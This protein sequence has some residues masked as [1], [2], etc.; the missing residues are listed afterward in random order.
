[1]LRPQ[2]TASDRLYPP[3]VPM[4]GYGRDALRVLREAAVGSTEGV[5]VADLAATAEEAG[6]VAGGR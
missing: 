4:L 6:E 1:M 5:T 2:G 3:L